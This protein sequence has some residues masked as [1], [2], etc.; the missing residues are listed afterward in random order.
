MQKGLIKL[1]DNNKVPKIL[2]LS[3]A[4]EAIKQGK[5]GE[6]SL[7]MTQALCP[8]LDSGSSSAPKVWQALQNSKKLR[9]F[10]SHSLTNWWADIHKVANEETVII[11]MGKRENSIGDPELKKLLTYSK[12]I[13]NDQVEITTNE[14]TTDDKKD[15]S[16]LSQLEASFPNIVWDY[17]AAYYGRF[18]I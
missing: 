11:L 15:K 3:S 12:L 18:N 14:I 7:F 13:A 5:N 10:I 1:I 4:E 16:L 17:H 9:E 6:T 8:I 2:G